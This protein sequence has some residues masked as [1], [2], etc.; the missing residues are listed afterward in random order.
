MKK[1]PILNLLSRY[2]WIWMFGIHTVLA[3]I[4]YAASL[5]FGYVLDD[6]I[7]FSENSYVQKG[8]KGIWDILS[9][10]S[11]TGYF[12]EQKDLVAGARYRPL[13]LVS[14]A[15]DFEMFGNKPKV[16]H[17][18]NILMYAL[19]A[20]LLYSLIKILLKDQPS[21]FLLWGIP[22]I[23]SV[24]FLTHPIHS[25]AV[26]NIKGRDEIMCLLF[27]LAASISWIKQFD[28]GKKKFGIISCLCFLAAL[29]SKENAITFLAIMPISVYYFRNQEFKKAILDSW[30]LF[31]CATLFVGV[32]WLVIGYLLS[33]GQVIT[34]LMNNPFIGMTLAE[35][36]A[37]LFYTFIWYY[38]LLFFPH[39]L[40]HDYYPYHVPKSEW[41]DL[42]PLLSLVVTLGLL[43]LAYRY[44]KTKK[45]ISYCLLYYFITF[46]I[47]SNLVFPVGT[48]MNERFLFMPSVAFSFLSAYFIYSLFNYTDRKLFRILA[49]S[50]FGILI[51]A[52]SAKT[53]QRVPDWKDGFTL[54]L[55]AVKVSKNSAR[56]NLF[57]G[58]SYFQKS[59]SEMD[60]SKKSTY[61]QVAENYID[62]ALL[63]FPQYGQALNMKAG[64]LAEWLKRNND[65]HTFL[66]K[67]ESVI[68]IK[69]DLDFVSKYMDYLT[70]DPENLGIMF[71]YL[72]RVGYEILYKEVQNY[73]FAL[74][75]LG[76]AYKLKND[77]AELC[78][79]ISKVYTDFAK[80]GKVSSGKI[81]E[82][83]SK[84]KEFYNQAAALD[85]KYVQ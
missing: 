15:L 83:E 46:S 37:T 18:I 30:P 24:L 20:T 61:L 54:N 33:S 6:I 65:I 32:R 66:K 70:K 28:S 69:P 55:A 49:M 17:L 79:F 48:F 22:S 27:C 57:T 63:I 11:F 75:F 9:T 77:D 72:K 13:S 34:D 82:Y 40:T 8:I 7:V 78:Y 36:S 84:A 50:I 31:V 62:R 58:V 16:S 14:F 26:A 45:I 23:T 67:L 80:F 39:P 1:I 21:R 52:Y 60:P 38:K 29:F 47:V 2:D 76:M 42:I 19:T 12:G 41:T 43:Y 5:S 10:E 4:L 71:P 25:E 74:H 81:L 59:Q 64:I 56:I 68:K 35:K 44:R 73:Q 51:T 85:P 53:I 3:L